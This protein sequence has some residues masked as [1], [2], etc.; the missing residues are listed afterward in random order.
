MTDN[1]FPP[2]TNAAFEAEYLAYARRARLEFTWK[3]RR[4]IIGVLSGVVPD[5]YAGAAELPLPA[6]RSFAL[7]LAR[8]E[9]S[10]TL[11][12]WRKQITPAQK[13]SLDAA[14]QRLQQAAAQVSVHANVQPPP[15]ER[16][17]FSPLLPT[18]GR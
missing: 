10:A 9:S 17:K 4:A 1:P 2:P 7:I 12:G 13:R 15:P 5:L 8:C 6:L 18:P 11:L 3:Q 14:V 16:A